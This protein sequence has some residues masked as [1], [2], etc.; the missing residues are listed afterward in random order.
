MG[1]MLEAHHLGLKAR[2]LLAHTRPSSCT[3]W[4]TCHATLYT[5]NIGMGWTL[6]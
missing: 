2:L 4:L 3:R 6:H 5:H 1:L